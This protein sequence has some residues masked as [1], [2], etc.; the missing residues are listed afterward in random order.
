MKVTIEIGEHLTLNNSDLH[1]D[2][3][4]IRFRDMVEGCNCSLHVNITELQEAL[5]KMVEK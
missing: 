5:R 2:A 1:D 4:I 3:V